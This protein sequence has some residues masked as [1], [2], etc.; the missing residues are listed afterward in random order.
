MNREIEFRGKRIDN[1]EW[2]YGLGILA[3]QRSGWVQIQDEGADWHD[4]DPATVGQYTGLKDKN[5]V[6]I[7][8]GDIVQRRAPI[9]KL[10]ERAPSGEYLATGKVVWDESSFTE[11]GN[12]TV[13][14]YDH[15][16][17]TAKNILFNGIN[18]WHVI[19]NPHDNPELLEV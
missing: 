5:G 13:S 2:V 12:Y 11:V 7:F 3:Y 16:G 1:G 6:K 18:G 19:G 4:V 15:L 14:T 10:G 9:Y 8:E 17:N